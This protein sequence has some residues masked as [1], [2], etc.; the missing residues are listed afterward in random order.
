MTTAG[1]TF[2]GFQ[3]ARGDGASPEVF[4]V[5]AEITDYDGP[6]GQAAVI[7]MSHAQSTF[8]DK[9]MGVPDEGQ[10]TISGNFIGTDAAQTGLRTDRKN[11]TRR[12]FRATFTD[13]GP[14]VANFAGFVLS[15]ST[16]G[17]VD[18]KISFSVTIE[19][20]GEVVYS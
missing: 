18:D 19:I 1:M 13:S 20:D 15:F 5:I 4:T 3:L 14:S 8:K 6:G 7:D 17:A 16:R 9:K 12:N 10:F 2:E 11:R